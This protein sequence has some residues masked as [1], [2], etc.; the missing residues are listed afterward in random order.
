MAKQQ[1]Q[2]R[3]RN[4][5]R[6]DSEIARQTGTIEKL[7]TEGHSCPDAQRQLNELKDAVALL[8]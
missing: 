6:L 2:E 4:M 1:N 5:V 8:R 7:Q 3:E